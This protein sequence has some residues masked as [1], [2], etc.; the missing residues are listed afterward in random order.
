[1][2]APTI[3][4]F[5]I[6]T[7]AD[8]LSFLQAIYGDRCAMYHLDDLLKSKFKPPLT[9]QLLCIKTTD[10]DDV[11]ETSALEACRSI[12]PLL[13][14]IIAGVAKA[15]KLGFDRAVIA[16]DHGFIL[17]HEQAA[18][19][20]VGKPAGDWLVVKDRFL[21]G[22][23]SSSNSVCTFRPEEVGIHG[24]FEQYAVPRSLGTFAKTDSYYHGGLSLQE[25]IV[26]LI[27]VDL[28]KREQTRQYDFKISLSY[29]NGATA[30]I[31]ARRPLIDISIFN[32]IF[33]EQE[34]S[35]QLLAFATDQVGEAAACEF[36]NPDTGMVTAM[37]GQAIRV[38]LKMMD[39]FQGRFQVRALD[40]ST[41][42]VHAV[43]DLETDY[44]E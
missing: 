30:K 8:R 14:K 19:D 25:S 9:T 24:S 39:T 27:T 34:I 12:S 1:M 38:P 36:V 11:G 29:R 7:P 23:G 40:P 20:V 18:G 15:Q 16:T 10:L 2:L 3:S 26:P 13:Q 33:F 44:M 17:F 32:D 42:L 31:T 43:L 22:H 41:Q 35:F 6:V 21:M 4:S 37:S 5:K 28:S